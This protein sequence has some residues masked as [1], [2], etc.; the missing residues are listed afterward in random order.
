MSSQ[1]VSKGPGIKESHCW[2]ETSTEQECDKKEDSILVKEWAELEAEF[3]K[4]CRNWHSVARARS[5]RRS[6]GL[7]KNL[8]ETYVTVAEDSK[9]LL[10]ACKMYEKFI[11]RFG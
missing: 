2:C 10:E 1:N 6:L 8:P 3:S 5:G 9:S 11:K 4:E 7:A